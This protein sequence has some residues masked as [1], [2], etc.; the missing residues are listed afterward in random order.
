MIDRKRLREQIKG[1]SKLAGAIRQQ[2]AHDHHAGEGELQVLPIERVKLNPDNPRRLPV[3]RDQVE[4]LH[5]DAVRLA[6]TTSMG[7]EFFD[8]VRSI[9]ESGNQSAMDSIER[10]ALLAES[11]HRRGLIQPITAFADADGGAT[12]MAGERRF[13]AHVLLG[14][15]TIRALVRLRDT[16]VL[17]DRAGALIENIMREDLSTAEK[18][19]SIASLVALHEESTG[20]EMTSDEL[21]ELIHESPRTCQRYLRFLAAPPKIRAMIA[22]GALETVRDIEKALKKAQESSESSSVAPAGKPRGRPRSG[23]LLGSAESAAVAREILD[24]WLVG[25][26]EALEVGDIDWADLRQAQAAWDEFMRLVKARLN[27]EGGR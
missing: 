11:I 10:I 19:E 13:L 16:N 5:N 23:V 4:Q 26:C 8:A 18:V 9:T 20:R 6:G 12:I 15:P 17:R 22:S 24:G 2:V 25:R 14:R 27:G 3:T 21:H 7:D 1:D